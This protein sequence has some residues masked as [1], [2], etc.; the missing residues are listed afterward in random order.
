MPMIRKQFFIDAAASA[1]LK[2]VA[3]LRGVSEAV[4]IREAIHQKLTA[5]YA[6]EAEWKGQWQQ[7]L[8]GIS[9]VWAD[10]DDM[11]E[12]VRDLRRGGSRRLKRLGL[13][14]TEST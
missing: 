9:G 10:R 3:L 5:D 1:R 4:F 2:R 7:A 12:F 8:K 13:N 11:Q 14:P 6:A